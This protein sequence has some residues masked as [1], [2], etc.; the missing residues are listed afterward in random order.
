MFR[1]WNW[2]CRGFRVFHQL[3]N[4]QESSIWISN[5]L[6]HDSYRLSIKPSNWC[7]SSWIF[8]VK[9]TLLRRGERRARK[10]TI[11]SL[12]PVNSWQIAIS[13][14]AL[15][16]LPGTCA[17]TLLLWRVPKLLF[18]PAALPAKYIW[19]IERCR[20]DLSSRG[21]QLAARLQGCTKKRAILSCFVP[22]EIDCLLESH[23]HPGGELSDKQ[24]N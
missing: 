12:V 5:F 11:L 20:G 6:F 19:S 23:L 13:P 9:S 10:C 15:I 16:F 3:N 2:D 1:V 22:R 8:A 7:F 4:W 17:N 24:T 18:Y 21:S 14:A